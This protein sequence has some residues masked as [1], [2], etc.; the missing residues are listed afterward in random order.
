MDKYDLPA[1]LRLECEAVLLRQRRSW[2]LLVTAQTYG[3]ARL[4]ARHIE[5]ASA[6]LDSVPCDAPSSP[7]SVVEGV[8]SEIGVETWVKIMRHTISRMTNTK[9]LLRKMLLACNCNMCCSG[10]Q[11]AAA[12]GGSLY[13]SHHVQ[14]M[15]LLA[16][17]TD[18]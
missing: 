4:L 7:S 8:M 17:L 11:G 18:T 10:A 1:A 2:A 12:A 13:C 15:C 6:N 14:F 16:T 5:W 3:L 9:Q